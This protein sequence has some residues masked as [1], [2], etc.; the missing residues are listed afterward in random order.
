MALS[1]RFV[2]LV[3][4]L[5]AL[6]AA[7]AS[8]FYNKAQEV[9]QAARVAMQVDTRLRDQLGV[10]EG[11]RALYQSDNA[12]SGFAVRSYLAALQP[13]AR[14]PG[15]QGIGIAIAMR[16][17]T[18]A[19]AED[20]LRENY[21]QAIRVWPATDQPIGFPIV[22]IEPDD[23]LNHVALGYD[24][25]SEPVRRAAMRRAWQT[26]RPAASGIVELVQE[27]KA[28]SKQAGFLIYV[29]VYAEPTR[30]AVFATARGA[31]PIEAFV[32]APF[33]ID[34]LMTAV[35]GSQLDQV[36]GIEMLAGEGPAAT[37]VFRRGRIGWDAHEQRIQVADRQWVMRISYGRFID[38]IGRPLAILLFG[39]AL[40]LL[41]MQLHRLQQR[42]L[43]AF[44]TLT[45]ERERHA[46][47]RE[48]MIGEMAHRMKNAFAR[49][50]ALARIT[51]R[52]SDDLDDFQRR[53]DGRMRALSDAK[54]ML[55][56][57]MVESVDLGRIIRRELEISG[58]PETRSNAPVL[59]GPEVR[60]DDEGAQA[61]ALAVHELVTNSVK[62]GALAGQG[63][64]AIGW[65]RDA[66]DVALDW[67]ESG[68]PET[69]QFDGESFGT[70]FIRALIER[71][72]GG[73]WD[74]RA[75]DHSL[76]IAIRWP[77]AAD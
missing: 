3:I 13:R 34:N 59:S 18:P 25:Y 69:P 70:R 11:V 61:I 73:S 68:L 50:G 7:V 57:G 5:A 54:Q 30:P 37:R 9:D 31:R 72:L 12:A 75:G 49:I 62:Y 15:M 24:M 36:A 56:T 52:E 4:M 55:V 46:E 35:L 38:R 40:S 10:L 32:Y 29:P 71:Q 27:R 45:E 48:L 63:T 1:V 58:W 42:R 28:R 67:S 60:L 43:A 19:A 65:R 2:G 33:R 51:A 6:V 22:L 21:G 23:P 26:G 76:S 17:A 16:R 39:A 77:A 44:Q 47:A 41:A 14:A 64:L 53:F 66:G 20:R 8:F 74:R